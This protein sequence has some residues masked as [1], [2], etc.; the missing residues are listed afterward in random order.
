M[1]AAPELRATVRA[2]VGGRPTEHVPWGNLID[3][4]KS[5]ITD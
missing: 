4:N 2:A 1:R 3:Y 5:M